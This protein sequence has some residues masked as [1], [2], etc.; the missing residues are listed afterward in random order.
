MFQSIF[1]RS[2]SQELE[3][4]CNLL[5]AE[6]VG[7]TFPKGRSEPIAQSKA[8]GLGELNSYQAMA[9]SVSVSVNDCF[10]RHDAESGK[11]AMRLNTDWLSSCLL[12]RLTSA[13]S[14][15]RPLHHHSSPRLLT[16]LQPG[17]VAVVDFLN[18]CCL[19]ADT[20]RAPC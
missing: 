14:C 13:R 2:I 1:F 8:C 17:R 12:S 9:Q 4:V 20:L 11:A 5:L 16:P 19:L 10:V 18:Y 3:R 7:S 6:V 15:N